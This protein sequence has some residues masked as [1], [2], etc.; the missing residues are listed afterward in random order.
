MRFYHQKGQSMEIF[1]LCLHDGTPMKGHRWPVEDPVANFCLITGMQEHS[2]RYDTLAKYLNEK[3]IEVYVLD[4]LGQGLNAP[5]V[6]EQMRWPS[7]G[8]AKNVEGVALMCG[9][10]KEN[11]K[12]TI[13]AGHSMGSFITQRRLQLYPHVSDGTIIIGSNGGQKGLMSVASFLANIIVHKS[14]WNRPN[15]FL[16]NLALGGYSKA[17]KGAKTPIDWLSYDEENVRAYAQD[18]YCGYPPTG[19]FWKEFLRG[20]K[21]IWKTKQMKRVVL[22]ERI[23]IIAG[24]EDPVGRN[25]KGPKW[26]LDR[27]SAL[28]VERVS[29]KLY[30]KMRHE[31]VNEAEK[32]EVFADIANFILE[33]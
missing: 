3:K 2:A 17:V 26:L 24:E 11:G 15:P 9:L 32:E 28:G 12:P 4:A 29:L 31:I 5:K 14:N 1:S 27:Y 7:D 22:D 19:G 16:T 6:E 18:E 10:A 25:G 8:F 20:L 21:E 33:K 30:P 13:Q 23:F